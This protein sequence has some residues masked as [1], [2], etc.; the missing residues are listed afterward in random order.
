MLKGYFI[1]MQKRVIDYAFKSY[2]LKEHSDLVQKA[3]VSTKVDYAISELN[4]KG[5]VSPILRHDSKDLMSS[6]DLM[7]YCRDNGLLNE[8]KECYRINDASYKRTNRLRERIERMLLSGDCL[9]LTITFNDDT[10][11]N[12]TDKE[13]RVMVSR[14][15]KSFGCSYVAN[16]DYGK[17]NHREHYHAVINASRIDYTLWYNKGYG[18][19]NGEK[20]R[21]RNIQSDKTKLAKYICKLS[22]HA[23]KETTKRSSLIYSR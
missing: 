19:V 16:V 9:F 12:T 21:N 4:N 14:Y 18:T 1:F 10:L 6:I 5:V 2:V 8:L 17:E 13:R 23:I 15:L 20:I 11:Q 3:K 7:N 22:N